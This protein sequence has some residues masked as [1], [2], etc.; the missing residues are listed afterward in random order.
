MQAM[1]PSLFLAH[2]GGPIKTHGRNS[3][4]KTHE[5]KLAK[6][7]PLKP[8]ARTP[9]GNHS[10][11]VG[12][13][14]STKMFKTNGGLDN[15]PGAKTGAGNYSTQLHPLVN[16]YLNNG[17]VAQFKSQPAKE[18][19]AP[20]SKSEALHLPQP[21]FGNESPA[22]VDAAHAEIQKPSPAK[23]DGTP[24]RRKKGKEVLLNQSLNQIHVKEPSPTKPVVAPRV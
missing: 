6:A 11:Q 18:P 3:Q 9:L 15:R 16:E 8:H 10:T 5:T 21:A 23:I 7:D 19:A 22:K 4:Q 13:A 2:Q 14:G 20:R 24:Q 1:D 12:M 17:G